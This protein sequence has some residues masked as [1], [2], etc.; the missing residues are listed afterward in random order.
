MRTNLKAKDPVVKTHEGAR[1][2]YREKTI[3]KLRRSLSCCLLWENTFYEDGESIAGRIAGYVPQCSSEELVSLVKEVRDSGIRH[4][5][6][7][8]V[9]EM[10]RYPIFKPVIA[11]LVE[12]VCDRPDQ[13]TELL[14]IY[15]QNRSDEKVK[16]IPY[17]MLKGGRKALEKFDAYTLAKY[18]NEDKKIK[19]RDVVRLF[20]PKPKDET[21]ALAFKQLLTGELKRTD[22]WE[23]LLSAGKDKRETFTK[24]I[25]EKKLGGLAL[26]RNL[27]NMQESGVD[28]SLVKEAIENMKVDRIEPFRLLKAGDHGQRYQESLENRL[29]ESCKKLTKIKGH[30]L[31]LLDVSGSMK[32]VISEKSEV[33]RCEVAFGLGTIFKEI[34][35]ETTIF[36]FDSQIHPIHHSRG[37]SLYK[38]GQNPN[39]GA[40]YIGRCLNDALMT[41]AKRGISQTNVVIITDMQVHDE[42]PSPKSFGGRGF[43]LNVASY[44]PSIAHGAWEEMTGFSEKAVEY[45]ARAWAE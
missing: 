17:Q 39:G 2:V 26:I 14:S 25:Q 15:W 3:E 5:P 11:E 44:E 24:L 32:A 10:M 7:L 36:G 20:H 42:V 19:L 12:Y 13:L 45:I 30:T 38:Q 6:L 8:V 31:V 27:R 23:D 4:A 33:R 18:K 9:R 1:A 16:K 29:F 41:I 40:T 37:F 22:T 21:Q 43:M 34:C 28:Y 35:E